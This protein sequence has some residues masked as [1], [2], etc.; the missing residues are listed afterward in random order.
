MGNHPIYK[1]HCKVYHVSQPNSTNLNDMNLQGS[2]PF[3]KVLHSLCHKSIDLSIFFK[4]GYLCKMMGIIRSTGLYTPLYTH[5]SRYIRLWTRNISSKRSFPSSSSYSSILVKSSSTRH[6]TPNQRSLITSSTTHYA[7]HCRFPYKAHIRCI[8]SP[9]QNGAIS[10][11]KVPIPSVSHDKSLNDH[12]PSSNTTNVLRDFTRNLGVVVSIIGISFA[13]MKMKSFMFYYTSSQS[14]LLHQPQLAVQLM[15]L[16]LPLL[17]DQVF[18]PGNILA[19][20]T[21]SPRLLSVSL[22]QLLMVCVLFLSLFVILYV[23]CIRV[24][25]HLGSCLLLPGFSPCNLNPAYI[26]AYIYPYLLSV[27]ISPHCLIIP[28]T[29]H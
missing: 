16:A 9:P 18:H 17:D 12:I 2:T 20:N 3:T 7:R 6:C 23:Y 22:Q 27:P 25:H 14:L 8:S 4:N 28:Y 11:P 26:Y 15:A 24:S 19:S 29:Y 10:P 5:T 13:Y 21:P 1:I